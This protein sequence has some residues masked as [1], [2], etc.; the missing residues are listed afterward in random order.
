MKKTLTT[1]IITMAMICFMALSFEA[2]AQ[3][4]TNNNDNGVTTRGTYTA[5]ATGKIVMRGNAAT[6]LF[7][8]TKALGTTANPSNTTTNVDGRIPGIVEWR[9]TVAQTVQPSKYYTDLIVS[10]GT[11]GG[12]TK[13]L[14]GD[15]Y[16]AGSY[17]ASGADRSYATGNF[18][19]DGL[20]AQTIF[21]EGAATGLLNAYNNLDLGVYT[22]AV[23]SIK[24]NTGVV[25]VLGNFTSSQYG[26][27]V[28]QNNFTVEGAASIAAGTIT[29]DGTANA[30]TFTTIGTGTFALNGNFSTTNF[31]TNIT[32]LALTSTGTF[33]VGATTSLALGNSATNSLIDMAAGSRLDVAGSFTNG[34][35]DR[36]NMTFN[37]SST[38]TYSGAG[39][40]QLMLSTVA[41]NK[42]G[43][44]VTT[45][46]SKRVGTSATVTDIYVATSLAVGTPSTP[47]S[48]IDL[49][50]ATKGSVGTMPG[51]IIDVAAAA[52]NL[53]FG[54]GDD[55]SINYIT[56]QVRRSGTLVTT[57][58]YNFNNNATQMTFSNVTGT[59]NV[60]AFVYPNAKPDT[61]TLAADAWEVNRTIQLAYTGTAPIM[62]AIKAGY[63]IGELDPASDA[64]RMK[65]G[66]GF[67][68][69][70]NKEKVT[71]Q[72]QP[73]VRTS[74]STT[75]LLA[76]SGGTIAFE[77][78]PHTMDDYGKFTTGSAL[79]FSTKNPMYTIADGRWTQPATWDEG[80]IPTQ[81]DSA[82]VR[83]F[84]YTGI[85][86]AGG[87][88]GTSGYDVDEVNGYGTTNDA[89][90][91]AYAITIIEKDAVNFKHPALLIGNKDASITASTNLFRTRLASSAGF[92]VPG[93]LNLN[94][95]AGDASAADVTTYSP[96]T[97]LVHGLY[98]ANTT[99]GAPGAF[100]AAQLTNNGTVVNNS[101]TIELG[102]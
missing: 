80:I 81:F 69:T 16:V 68:V 23:N 17:T 74:N 62:S 45:G 46:G 89:N 91:A 44:L 70:K 88:Y 60:S 38:V 32:K 83:H 36:T 40:N 73:I 99:G 72:G 11:A 5:T 66:E 37:G 47:T 98:I 29:L 31:G 39:A 33:T 71:M 14:A 26:P 30:V 54:S 84:V 59:T 42:Y 102:L 48:Y 50:P 21:A 95:T 90:A 7:D 6:S 49:E 101:G 3:K 67:D 51:H 85:D 82:V 4:F 25:R 56:G 100:G 9:S 27:M 75:Q 13:T 43:N 63:L 93:I 18:H 78:T 22:G 57:V 12:V 97:D 86:V 55:I 76:L 92:L 41:T 35:D 28:N 52:G 64:T 79:L 20:A 87:T 77:A 8:G 61:Y 96:A 65:F 34:F 10:G 15:I 19:Y 24:T 53:T 58:T 1:K 2:T 94:T